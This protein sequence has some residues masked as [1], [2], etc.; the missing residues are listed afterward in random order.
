MR[1]VVKRYEELTRDE[2]YELI[3][4]RLAVFVV[5]QD[6]P[7][8]DLDGRDK[9]AIHVWLEDG[10]GIQAYLRVMDRGVESKDVSLGRVIAARRRMGLGSQ[11]LSEGIRVAREC[12]RAERIY[13]EAQVYARSFYERQGFVQIS[14][15]FLE[16][17]I[18]HIRMIREEPL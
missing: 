14:E 16:D 15:E 10:E 7:Y 9:E 18:P 13:L 5:E 8:Q 12:F 2:L 4:L 3:R 11:I 6:C 1:V 17:G